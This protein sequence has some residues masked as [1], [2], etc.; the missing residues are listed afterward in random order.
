V[1]SSLSASWIKDVMGSRGGEQGLLSDQV[2][3]EQGGHRTGVESFAA[4]A[5]VHVLKFRRYP[6]VRSSMVATARIASR[7]AEASACKRSAS[8]LT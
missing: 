4:G 5:V 2:G 6:V 8:A 3:E 1:A 7:S